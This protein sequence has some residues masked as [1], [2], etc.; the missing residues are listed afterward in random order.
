MLKVGDIVET[1]F[2]DSDASFK[3]LV[4]HIY[5]KEEGFSKMNMTYDIATISFVAVDKN[6]YNRNPDVWG[7]NIGKLNNWNIISINGVPYEP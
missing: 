5:N 3:N 6:T 1:R 4:V 2:C 7:Y